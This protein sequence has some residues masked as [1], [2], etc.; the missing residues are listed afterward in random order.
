M[1]PVNNNDILNALKQHLDLMS[2][3]ADHAALQLAIRTIEKLLT[4]PTL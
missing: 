2:R 3:G 4:P 1:R